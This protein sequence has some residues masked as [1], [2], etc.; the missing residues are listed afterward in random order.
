MLAVWL[1]ATWKPGRSDERRLIAA[2]IAVL[3]AS[4][5]DG[6]RPPDAGRIAN[7][8]AT[9]APQAATAT[10]ANPARGADRRRR[11]ALAARPVR[12]GALSSEPQQS[13]RGSRPAAS[14]AYPMGRDVPRD[15]RVG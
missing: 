4:A 7:P 11:S 10:I 5:C 13:K 3:D 15:R 1:G 2:A 6:A 8:S 12:S 9:V 14:S